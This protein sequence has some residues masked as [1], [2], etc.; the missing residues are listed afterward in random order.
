[1]LGNGDTAFDDNG[2]LKDAGTVK[3]LESCF[4]DFLTFAERKNMGKKEAAK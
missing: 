2:D 3:F 1:M 4:S